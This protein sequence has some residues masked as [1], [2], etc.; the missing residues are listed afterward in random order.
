MFLNTIIFMLLLYLWFNSLYKWNPL[1]W[2]FL[3][4]LGLIIWVLSKYSSVLFFFW[5]VY[6]LW[7]YTVHYSLKKWEIQTKV[8]KKLEEEQM[9][10]II[11]YLV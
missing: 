2:F 10:D 9:S 3:I 8:E 11:K 6:F 7:D 1:L 4:F 5:F